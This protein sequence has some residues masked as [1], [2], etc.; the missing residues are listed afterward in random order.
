MVPRRQGPPLPRY[1]Y[2]SRRRRTS[3]DGPPSRRASLL[4]VRRRTIDLASFTMTATYDSP[5][6]SPLEAPSGAYCRGL[7][8]L[9]PTDPEYFPSFLGPSIRGYGLPSPT[10]FG[11]T[12]YACVFDLLGDTPSESGPWGSLRDLLADT[13][14]ERRSRGPGSH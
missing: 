6:T 11:P 10:P 7:A 9:S 5:R 3:H 4:D 12:G 13:P 8:S 14:S 2:T 1:F